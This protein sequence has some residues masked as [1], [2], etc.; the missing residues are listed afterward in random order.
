MGTM[1]AVD[2][3]Q[4]EFMTVTEGKPYNRA[5]PDLETLCRV[6]TT[7]MHPF[8]RLWRRLSTE[9]EI[10]AALCIV[11]LMGKSL[12]CGFILPPE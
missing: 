1:G 3:G 12:L 11:V 7:E 6:S 10:L 9:G 8:C 2:L 5:S 4:F